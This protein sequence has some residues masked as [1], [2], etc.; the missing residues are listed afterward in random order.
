MTAPGPTPKSHFE[1]RRRRWRY[2]AFRASYVAWTTLARQTAVA[3]SAA[4]IVVAL[5]VALAAVYFTARHGLPLWAVTLPLAAA[6]AYAAAVTTWQFAKV[7]REF[8]LLRRQMRERR[9]D[10]LFA[11]GYP[12]RQLRRATWLRVTLPYWVAIYATGALAAVFFPGRRDGRAIVFCCA[13]AVALIPLSRTLAKWNEKHR[14]PNLE[15]LCPR[16]GYDLTASPGRCP[17]C[18]LRRIH[19]PQ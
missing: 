17:E 10:D 16:C 12:R 1:S 9:R 18:G 14:P 7:W 11:G 15:S 2:A 19:A 6:G 13:A 3:H 8:P 5:V 4:A